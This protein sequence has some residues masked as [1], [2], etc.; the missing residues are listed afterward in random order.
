MNSESKPNFLTSQAAKACTHA[1][2]FN[3][4]LRILKELLE[5]SPGNPKSLAGFVLVFVRVKNCA[6]TF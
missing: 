2:H 6:D 4:S 3:P 5:G 1:T